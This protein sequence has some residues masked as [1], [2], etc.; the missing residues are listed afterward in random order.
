MLRDE[1]IEL[2]KSSVNMIMLADYYGLKVN[3]SGYALCPFH[4]DNHPSMQVFSGYV[5]RDGFYCRSC[6][7]GGTIFNFVMQYE[8]VSFEK[9]VRKI[10]SIFSVPIISDDKLSSE[11]MRRIASNRI[12]QIMNKEYE[13]TEFHQMLSCADTIHIFEK[14]MHEAVPYSELFC[15]IGNELPMIQADWDDR[16]RRYCDRR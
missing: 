2:V 13:K 3:R 7:V 5:S 6:G 14:V 1:D 11:D 15:S 8:N 12:K 16:H 4:E 9:S 10:A